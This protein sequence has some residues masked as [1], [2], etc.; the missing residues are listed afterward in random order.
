[1]APPT[2][3]ESNYLTIYDVAKKQKTTLFDK[4]IYTLIEHV[5]ESIAYAE[6]SI[7][8]INEELLQYKGMPGT[9]TRHFYNNICNLQKRKGIPV[10]YLEIGT[11]CGS[12]SISAM[13]KNHIQDSLFIDNFSI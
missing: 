7:S 12:S 9:K 5:A 13:F 8:N 6:N 4:N 10:K 2:K 11:W 3:Q 1:M